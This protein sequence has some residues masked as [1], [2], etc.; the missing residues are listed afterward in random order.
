V[1]QFFRQLR[2]RRVVCL[3]AA[4]ALLLQ[5]FFALSVATQAAA[6][7]PSSTAGIFFVICS[8]H[9]DPAVADGAG[10]PAKSGVHC[11]SCTLSTSGAG[12][13][14]EAAPVPVRLGLSS[15][16][17]DFV[18]AEACLSFHRARAGLSQAP[19]QNA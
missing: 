19:P 17:T 9:N 6:Q 13:L 16:R 10:V 12:V 2:L 15:E 5:S 1:V 3:A 4:Y 18:T 8:T 11:P 14:P 7:D